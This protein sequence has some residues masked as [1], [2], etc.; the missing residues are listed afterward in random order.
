MLKSDL[1]MGKASSTFLMFSGI[2]QIMKLYVGITQNVKQGSQAA[3]VQQ[4][5]TGGILPL[6]FSLCP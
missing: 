3:P 2:A 4:G 6:Q 1:G 5:F